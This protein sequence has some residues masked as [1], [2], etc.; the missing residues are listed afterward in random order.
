[1]LD[2]DNKTVVIHVNIE[3]SAHALSS[4]VAVSKKLAGQNEKGHYQVDTADAL[5]KIISRFLMENNFD[6]YVQ[7]PDHYA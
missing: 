6:E 3:L 1:M 2:Q 4:V 7:N 5:N